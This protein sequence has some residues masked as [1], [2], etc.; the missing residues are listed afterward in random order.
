MGYSVFYNTNIQ[1]IYVPTGSVDAYKAAY[2]WDGYA[3]KIE[4]YDF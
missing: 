2:Y 4:D 1:A 3:N